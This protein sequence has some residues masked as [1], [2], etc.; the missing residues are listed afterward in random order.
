MKYT[1]FLL[2]IYVFSNSVAFA[3]LDKGFANNGVYIGDT[4]GYFLRVAIQP[5][6][7]IVLTGWRY[8][9][10]LQ[11]S[12][13]IRL[14]ADG[15]LDQNFANNG[16]F[17]YPLQNNIGSAGFNGLCFQPDNKIIL[18]GITEVIPTNLDFLICR[19]KSDGSP[20]SSFGNTG[21]VTTAYTHP[22]GV[23]IAEKLSSIA[24]QQDGKIL[25]YGSYKFS[26]DTLQVLRYHTN[27]KIDSSFAVSGRFRTSTGFS[28]PMTNDIAVLPD[29][30]IMLGASTRITTINRHCFTAIRLLSNG[31][32]DTS[33]N[34]TG[35]AYAEVGNAL[36]YCKA[37]QVQP[38]GKILL[39]GHA[40]S[41]IVVRFDTNGVLDANFGKSGIVKISKSTGNSLA[42]QPNGKIIVAGELDSSLIIYRLMPNGTI[43]FSFGINGS[44]AHKVLT[45][46]NIPYGLAHQQDDKL[47]VCGASSDFN[48]GFD[49]KCVVLRFTPN[50]T[51]ISP[52]EKNID[53]NV[54]PNPASDEIIIDNKTHKT[55]RQLSLFTTDS[56]LIFK[57]TLPNTN[58]LNTGNLSNGMY[59]L[60]VQFLGYSTATRKLI[61]QK[62]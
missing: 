23:G 48:A 57:H 27:G 47:L 4:N 44:V 1:F 58:R 37:M 50:A 33:F 28:F 11:N 49:A 14:N 9:S 30:R 59:I 36:V 39:V 15:S 26:L 8:I 24:L 53:F 29:G 31:D 42:M 25:A 46:R 54:Y 55:I 21:Y 35:V 17:R 19:L 13:T 61:I 5:D 45:R 2:L 32:L 38:D 62:K 52:T 3:Q 22:L 6:Q 56:K 34:H 16:E 10:N 40:D 7:K 41:L 20:D 12:I 60:N 43:D 18:G 51:N